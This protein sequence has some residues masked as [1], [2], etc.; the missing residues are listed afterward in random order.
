MKILAAILTCC[1][2]LG[3]CTTSPVATQPDASVF[4]DARFAPPSAAIRAADVFA[5][6]PEMKAYLA[7]GI[8]G[9]LLARGRTELLV[10]ALYKKSELKLDYDSVLTRNAAQAFAARSG[11]CLSLVI[12]TAAFA[13]ELGIPVRFQSVVTDELWGRGGGI[14]FVIDHINITLGQRIGGA[15]WAGPFTEAV[16]IDFLPPADLRGQKQHVLSEA[17]VLAMYM[18]NR[19]AETLAQ[20]R[21]DDAYWFAREAIVQDPGFVRALNTL[22]VVYRRHGDPGLAEHALRAAYAKQPENPQ[23]VFNLA[24]VLADQGRDGEAASLRTRLA[25]LQPQAPFGYL[26]RGLAALRNGDAKA[27]RDLFLREVD[28]APYNAQTHYWLAVAYAKL[29]EVPLAREQLELAMQTSASRHDR[30]IYAAKLE[31]Y[32]AHLTHVTQ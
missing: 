12:M 3:A 9:R 13:K 2:L 1:G 24:Q 23:I 16:T 28:R 19:A 7:G 8:E 14:D 21:V 26:D 32:Q 18:N 27:A 20:G 15:H 30:D 25:Q 6:S 10:D 22:G 4:A 11:N 17:T 29:G 31:R 5:L